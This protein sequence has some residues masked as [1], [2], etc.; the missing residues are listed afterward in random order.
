[1]TATNLL[2]SLNRPGCKRIADSLY[3]ILFGYSFF[4][5]YS[6]T[7]FISLG[8]ATI[9]LDY[10]FILVTALAFGL[11]IYTVILSA[12]NTYNNRNKSRL[13]TLL[14]QLFL[15]LLSYVYWFRSSDNTCVLV[16]VWLGI[17]SAHKNPY[18]VL[19]LALIIGITYVILAFFLSMCGIIANNR[20]NSFGFIYRTDYACHLLFLLLA[21]CFYTAD[22]PSCRGELGILAVFLYNLLIVGGKTADLCM[23]CVLFATYGR[24]YQIEKRVPYQDKPLPIALLFRI[25]Y[26]PC[27]LAD[28]LFRVF[29]KEKTKKIFRLACLWSFL[30]FAGIMLVITLAYH[31]IPVK[32]LDAFPIL[33][34]FRA[35][36]MLGIVGF[37]IYPISLFG[38]SV[39]SHGNGGTEGTVDFYY[40]LDCS[41]IK[42]LI[43]YG[44]IIFILTLTVMT[45]LQYRLYKNR[46][47]YE[48]FLLAVA[49]LDCTMEHHLTD[50]SYNLFAVLMLCSLNPED[51]GPP[52]LPSIRR[53]NRNSPGWV[54]FR[55]I[56]ALISVILFIPA[57]FTAYR[58]TTASG[59]AIPTNHAVII[60]PGNY[61][62]SFAL[63]EI[64]TQRAAAA[65]N[66]MLRH[67]DSVCVTSGRD[68]EDLCLYLENAGISTERLYTD[69]SSDTLAEALQYADELIARENLTSRKT[70]CAAAPE[71]ERVKEIAHTLGTPVNILSF[72]LHGIHYGLC[73]VSEQVK[74]LAFWI[75]RLL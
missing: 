43:E 71:R 65:A 61:G 50:I 19:R 1:M 72:Q 32:W 5:W 31:W 17:S 3:Y 35:R 67:S 75:G 20:G 24:H 48:C 26:L 22:R 18:R 73:F 64:T 69:T 7:T 6:K 53:K 40:F 14:L 66:Y 13:A 29:I 56:Y 57:A 44:L 25:L 39:I 62:E 45:V 4:Y 42:M 10:L 60:L 70:V 63:E 38:N 55:R 74:L 47:W 27:I 9:F 8:A 54:R 52:R 59:T 23:A 11:A 28:R 58:I 33:S 34:S 46:R 30:L 2:N 12:F 37:D 15:L 51:S 68:A 41:Y 16:M 49:A 21:Y 36:L